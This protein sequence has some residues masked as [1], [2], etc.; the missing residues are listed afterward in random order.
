MNTRHI[1]LKPKP[2]PDA[3]KDASTRLDSLAS[4]IR[5]NRISFEDA[6]LHYSADKNSRNGG[7]VAINPYSMSSKWKKQELDPDVSKVLDNL[8]ENEISDP[9]QTIDD[10]Q[11]T[12]FKVVKLISRSKEHRANIRNNFV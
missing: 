11:R 7:G 2:S 5:Q 3:L 1:I 9:F 8:K 10:K 4:A 12:V 6:A